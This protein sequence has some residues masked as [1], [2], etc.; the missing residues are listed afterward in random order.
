LFLDADVLPLVH[1]DRL[2][3]NEGYR[4]TGALFWR[5]FNASPQHHPLWRHCGVT[6]R[7]EWEMEAG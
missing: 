5:D 3:E 1:P 4:R 2:L 6:A 7:P